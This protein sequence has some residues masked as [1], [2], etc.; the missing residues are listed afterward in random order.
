VRNTTLAS[1]VARA[2]PNL[3]SNEHLGADGQDAFN[4]ACKL[5]LEGIVS[6]RKES[7]Y[8]SGRSPDCINSKNPNAPAVKRDE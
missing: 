3:R 2:A 8:H 7:R 1:L 6:K 4:H 5:D